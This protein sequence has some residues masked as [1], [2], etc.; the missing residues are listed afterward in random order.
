V[1]QRLREA[2]R[3]V[4]FGSDGSGLISET[5]IRSSFFTDEQRQRWES[6]RHRARREDPT[7]SLDLFAAG[8]LHGHGPMLAKLPIDFGCARCSPRGEAD[9]DASRDR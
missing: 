5:W 8:C 4:W 9:V 6:E 1:Y 3:E 2:H 7:P